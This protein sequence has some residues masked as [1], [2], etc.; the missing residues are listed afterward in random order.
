MF[1]LPLW[2]WCVGRSWSLSCTRMRGSSRTRPVW[3]RNTPNCWTRTR[4]SPPTSTFV[5]TSWSGFRVSNNRRVRMPLDVCLLPQNCV[6]INSSQIDCQGAILWCLLCRPSTVLGFAAKYTCHI[7]EGCFIL[8]IN[9]FQ[10]SSPRDWPFS[11]L[12]PVALKL[13]LDQ[14]PKRKAMSLWMLCRS[15]TDPQS[16]ADCAKHVSPQILAPQCAVQ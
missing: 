4:V 9:C 7:C 2:W 12:F 14:W 11:E 15:S 5:R 10:M 16:A 8:L 13:F 3:F 1:S 6:Q